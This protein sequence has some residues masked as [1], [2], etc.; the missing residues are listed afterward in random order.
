M[1][2]MVG[3]T[4]KTRWDGRNGERG[5]GNRHNNLAGRGSHHDGTNNDNKG[6]T[7][8]EM[9]PTPAL[10]ATRMLVGWIAGGTTTKRTTTIRGA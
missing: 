9:A 8:N 3:R 2:W 7:G 6:M 5:Q 1:G 10:Q 4:M